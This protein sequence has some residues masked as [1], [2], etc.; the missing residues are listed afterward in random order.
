MKL[1]WAIVSASVALTFGAVNAAGAVVL[2]EQGQPKATIV[3]S[4]QPTDQSREG[5][6]LL[7]DYLQRITGAR[8]EIRDDA[9]P[10]TGPRI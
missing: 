9:A 10:V 3:L 7:Q 6:T 4:A 5:A 8:L 1:W 2:V